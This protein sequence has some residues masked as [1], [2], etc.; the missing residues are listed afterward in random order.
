MAKKFDIKSTV[1]RNRTVAKDTVAIDLYAP[2]I[3]ENISPGQFVMV[4]VPGKFLRRPLSV[5]GVDGNRITLL[6]RIVGE[7]TKILASQRRNNRLK[8]LGP[9]GNSFPEITQRKIL[10]AGGIGI[11]PLLFYAN[12]HPRNLDFIYGET[13]NSYL[14]DSDFIP[15]SVKIS[16][17]DGSEGFLGNACELLRTLEPAPI[18][19]CG[20]EP[21]LYE[22]ASIAKR[23]NVPA[24]ISLE[25]RM[26]CGFGVCNGCAIET[27][28]GMKKVCTDGPIFPAETI[29]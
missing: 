17:D 18:L 12:R 25:S 2:Q 15:T 21:M 26:A 3:S 16:T 5:A 27:K 19:A 6:I 1:L 4:E 13:N 24:F 9:L 8:I 11:A 7:G 23:W 22:I 10:V 29:L 28:N 20:P 14:I